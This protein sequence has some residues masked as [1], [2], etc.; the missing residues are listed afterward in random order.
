MVELSGKSDIF[1]HSFPNVV[2]VLPT[3]LV[4][5]LMGKGYETIYLKFRELIERHYQVHSEYSMKLA[6]FKVIF[7]EN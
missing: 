5:A 2:F 1:Q 4:L 3:I 6:L 7:I